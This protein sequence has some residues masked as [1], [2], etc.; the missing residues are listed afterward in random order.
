MAGFIKAGIV[1]PAKSPELLKS[2]FPNTAPHTSVGSHWL[3]AIT[4]IGEG[5]P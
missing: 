5:T 2:V 1:N 3:L 4:T